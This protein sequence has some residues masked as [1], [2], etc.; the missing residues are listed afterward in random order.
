LLCFLQVETSLSGLQN[1]AAG[2]TVIDNSSAWRMDPS[3]KIDCS[4][5]ASSLTKKI[6]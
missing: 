6:K 4:C 1:A 2:T 3:K 5:N